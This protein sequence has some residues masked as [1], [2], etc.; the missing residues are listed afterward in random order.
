MALEVNVNKLEIP[1]VPQNHLPA[2]RRSKLNP[3]QVQDKQ[4]NGT[5]II[6]IEK[7]R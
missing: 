3:N 5:S 2:R 1:K 7:G 6:R 4:T